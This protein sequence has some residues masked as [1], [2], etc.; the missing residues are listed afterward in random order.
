M[1][2]LGARAEYLVRRGERQFQVIVSNPVSGQLFQSGEAVVL[3]LPGRNVAL[4]A[5]P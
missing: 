1:V 3:R 4:I 5:Q 2:Y